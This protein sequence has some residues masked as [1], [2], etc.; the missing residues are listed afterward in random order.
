MIL[1]NN[2]TKGEYYRDIFKV[3]NESIKNYYVIDYYEYYI[4]KPE[5]FS[6]P[7]HLNAVGA[8]TF[9]KRISNELTDIKKFLIH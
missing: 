8:E 9:S 3:I 4:N 5:Y 7:D 2:L 6:D 1:S